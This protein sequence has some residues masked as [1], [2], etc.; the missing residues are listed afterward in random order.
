MNRKQCWLL[1]SATGSKWGIN[2]FY[3]LSDEGKDVK[4][5][6]LN[7]LNH[8]LEDRAHEAVIDEE[9]QMLG[10]HSISSL[11]VADIKG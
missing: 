11:F 2:R 10:I 9:R 7:P 3:L 6:D 4:V 1:S 8:F 5:K